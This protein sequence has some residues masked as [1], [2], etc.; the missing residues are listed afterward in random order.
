VPTDDH[1]AA[2]RSLRT[3]LLIAFTALLL[4]ILY[5]GLKTSL[6][7]QDVGVVQSR[8][9]RL[10][11][12]TGTPP[13]LPPVFAARQGDTVTLVV[14]S[15][16]VAELHVHGDKERTISLRPGREATLTFTVTDAGRFPV[17]VHDPD[18]SMYPLGMLEVQPR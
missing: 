2:P 8:V 4:G 14:K 7:E 3:T 13:E 5:W 18:G 6:T 9:Y 10:S 1:E 16:R 15:D 17:H 11:V 12:S